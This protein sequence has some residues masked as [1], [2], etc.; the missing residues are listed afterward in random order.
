[1][2]VKRQWTG[3]LLLVI[4]LGFVAT[5][6]AGVIWTEDFSDVSDWVI[7]AQ[8]NG[9]AGASI[10]SLG[11]LGLFGVASN[12][13]FAAFGPNTAVLV[14]FAPPNKNDYAMDFT[15][16][17]LTDSTSYDIGLDEFDAG[18]NYLSTV[19]VFPNGTFTGTT[20]VSLGGPLT[21]NASTV[22]LLPKITVFTGNGDQTVRF[23][24][25]EFTVVPEPA[26]IFLV[27]AGLALFGFR[28]VQARKAD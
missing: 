2:S 4:S 25:M 11:G 7:I 22:F 15:V 14:P 21:Y 13:S 20:N 5:A 8:S 26:T 18:T 6:R 19:G 23:D 17:S 3:L 16:P 10:S 9:N 27:A 24:N 1:M 28:G 12:S